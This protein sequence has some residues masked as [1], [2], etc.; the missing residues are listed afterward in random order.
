MPAPIGV[1]VARLIGGTVGMWPVVLTVVVIGAV[2]PM[3][4]PALWPIPG[5]ARCRKPRPGP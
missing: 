3:I 1:L 2:V 4:V 5:R